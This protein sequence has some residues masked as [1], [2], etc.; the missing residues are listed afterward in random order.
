MSNEGR[1]IQR[2]YARMEYERKRSRFE[3]RG[4]A[5][6]ADHPNIPAGEFAGTPEWMRRVQ[7]D[8]IL[9]LAGDRG[10]APSGGGYQP[11]PR[12]P[13]DILGCGDVIP[14]D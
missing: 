11:L 3:E 12:D 10:I 5:W 8:A 13:E 2:I 4:Q 1:N 6:A 9:K 7:R 14:V